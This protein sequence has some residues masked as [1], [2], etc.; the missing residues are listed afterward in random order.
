MA[1]RGIMVL[2]FLLAQEGG[3]IESGKYSLSVS[4]R[5]TGVEEYRLE[6]FEDGKTVLFA[7]AKFELDLAG[8]KRAYLTDTVLTMDKSYAPALYAGFRRAGR[9]QDQ[10]K[11]QW[12]KGFATTP[13]KQIKTSAKFLLDPTVICHL[14][15]IVR[16]ADLTQ[17]RIRL[18]NPTALVDFDGSIEDKGEALLRRKESTLRVRELQIKLGYVAYTAHVDEKKRLIRAWSTVNNSLAELEGFEGYIPEGL[19]PEGIEETDVTFPSGAI[20]L[21]ATVAR[22]RGAKSCPAVLLVSD[23][24]PH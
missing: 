24:G 10:V 11:I 1:T 19:A 6:E 17:N 20:K 3:R 23:T 4:G 5:E 12:D 14:I 21:S 8:T 7:R 15:P 16:G 2:L 13:K 22:P 18:F 9:E